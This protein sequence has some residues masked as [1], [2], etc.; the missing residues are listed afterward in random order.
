MRATGLNNILL[1]NLHKEYI[2]SYINLSVFIGDLR[3]FVIPM[4]SAK[5]VS[6]APGSV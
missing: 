1:M 5:H 3:L 4:T 2:Y 6:E